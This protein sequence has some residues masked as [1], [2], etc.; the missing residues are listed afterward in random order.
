MWLNNSDNLKDTIIDLIAEMFS[1]KNQLNIQISREVKERV[2]QH[3]LIVRQDPNNPLY[4]FDHEEFY[5]FF[6]GVALSEK[7]LNVKTQEIKN[8]LRR[9]ILPLQTS[10]SIVS[11]IKSAHKDLKT[12]IENLDSVIKGETQF[13][14]VKE[15]VG[16][17][18][19][20]LLCNVK[21]FGITKR[22]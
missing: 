14:Y 1:E 2:K 22:V 4:R 12:V 5:E 9:A 6:L 18:V 11:K 7:I 13:S 20:R 3:A 10:E 21:L 19:I 17:I 16:G 8:L 15:N